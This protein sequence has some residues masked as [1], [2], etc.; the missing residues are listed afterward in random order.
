VILIAAFALLVV[1][2]IAEVGVISL[3]RSRAQRLLSRQP[4]SRDAQRLSQITQN[5]ERALGSFAVGRTTAVVTGLTSAIF[6]VNRELGFSWE[7]VVATGLVGF[8]VIAVVQ[9]VPRRLAGRSPEAF[10]LL[11]ARTMDALDSLFLIPAA[12]VESPAALITRLRTAQVE[13]AP[14]PTELEAILE[15]EN[16][17]GIEPEEREMIQRVIDIGDTAVHEAMVPRPDIVAVEVTSALTDAAQVAVDR[18]VS[19]VPVYEGS[20]DNIIGVLY[21]KDALAQLL[22]DTE[23]T[24]RDLM[25]PPMLVPESK[26]IDEL[27]AEFRTRRVHI[28]IVLDEY[29]GTAG[30]VTIEDLLEEIVGE[31]E[32]EFDRATGS[33]V[34]RLSDTEAILD[35]RA[36][37]DILNDL[38]GHRI[39]SED[40]DTVGGLVFD[41]L[42]KIPQVGDELQVDRIHLT[43]LRMEG[44][45]IARVRARC[46]AL[47]DSA[48]DDSPTDENLAA[49]ASNG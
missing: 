12:M 47:S 38:F 15:Q 37:T 8:L 28:A 41:R 36:S 17:A 19:R 40:F 27:L 43:V 31:I 20:I 42:G 49:N 48:T 11:F 44:R 14:E 39:E 29:G 25:R 46:E 18:G 9:A 23:I 24:L 7:A 33:E 1:E 35:G 32:D 2:A 21:A 30:L 4:D 26:L 6:L 5:R 13:H 10:A 3:S 34:M 45:R 22:G 16:G